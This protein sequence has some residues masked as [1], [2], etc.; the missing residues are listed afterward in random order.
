MAILRY[1]LINPVESGDGSSLADGPTGAVDYVSFLRNRINYSDTEGS[2]FGRSFPETNNQNIE[3]NDDRVYL[4][5]PKTLQTGYAPRY[6]QVDLGVAG[7]AAITALGGDLT[8]TTQVAKIV[9]DAA[10]AGLPEFAGSA[11]ADIINGLSQAG[12]L[13]GGVDANSIQALTRG[14]IFNPFKE[15][16]FAGLDFRTHNFTFKLLS[17]SENEAKRVKAIIDYFKQGA[18]P[19][20][21][22]ESASV[23][24]LNLSSNRFFEIPDSFNI[25]FLRVD[26]DGT[27][28]AAPDGQFM[29]FKI[30]PS[31]CTGV[32]VNYTPDGQYTSFK[33]FNGEMVQVPALTL[34]LTFAE[35]RLVTRQDVLEGF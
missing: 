7:A 18:M 11:A 23:S 15:Q 31:V 6:R 24:G 34:G 28:S 5:M 16:I 25:K 14:R 32:Q 8:D 22:G 29:H 35:Q 19:A 1:P 13:A 9:E 17:R 20:V 4:A 3:N 12:G 26:A 21:G 33:R 10:A 30:H 2:Y 27:S